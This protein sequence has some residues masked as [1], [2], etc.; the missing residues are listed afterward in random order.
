M[1]RAF[2]KEQDHAE[3]L[4]RPEPELPAGV[5]NHVTPAGAARF[6]ARR[7]ALLAERAQ[8]GEGGLPAARRREIDGEVRRLV[9]WLSPVARALHG[10][11][12]GD[13]VTVKTPSGDEEWEILAIVPLLEDERLTG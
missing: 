1:S 5:R 3:P 11:Q 9:S 8:L 12:V 13:L 7:E 4:L 10:A 2:V 6:R